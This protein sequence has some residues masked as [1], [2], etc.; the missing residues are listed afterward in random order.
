MNQIYS[1]ILNKYHTEQIHKTMLFRHWR[2][3]SMCLRKVLRM[4]CRD[5][6][7]K[8]SSEVSLCWEE[9]VK[10]SGKPRQLELAGQSTCKER[11]TKS[12][13]DLQEASLVFN[14]KL[15]SV[16]VPLLKL[17]QILSRR[18]AGHVGKIHHVI[19]GLGRWAMWYQPDIFQKGRGAG[20]W[21][22]SC[23][24]WWQSIMPT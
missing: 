15:T 19:R 1:P 16:S 13:K 10:N 5:G 11:A 12:F 8:Q 18:G 9:N 2:A 7:H 22:Q 4:Q 14:W 21:A 23:G 24:Q 20:D 3:G 6:E 17:P